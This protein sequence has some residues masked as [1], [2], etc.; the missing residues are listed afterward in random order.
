MKATKPTESRPAIQSGLWRIE[1]LHAPDPAAVGTTRVIDDVLTLGRASG[2]CHFVLEDDEASREHC[3]IGIADD[4]ES[5]WL[6][7]TGSRNGTFHDGARAQ[8]GV[9]RS[10]SVLRV[11]AHLLLLER[12]SPE[13]CEALVRPSDPTPGMVGESAAMH[14]LRA[15]LTEVASRSHPV[16]VLGESGTGKELVAREIHRHSGREGRFVAVNCAAIPEQLV[17]SE[18]FGHRRGAFTGA[19]AHSLGLFGEAEGGTIMLDEIAEMQAV[20]QAKLL[21]VLQSC[22]VRGV[23]E[24]RERRID[25]RVVAATNVDVEEAMARGQLRGDLYARLMG[26]RVFVPPLRTRRAD[27]LPTT[28]HFLRS[29]GSTLRPTVD[30]AEALLL[31]SWR[32]NVRE[33][34]QLV[35]DV[36]ERARAAGALQLTQLPEVMRVPVLAREPKGATARASVPIELRVPADRPPTAEELEH[37]LEHFGG[38]VAKVASYF[39]KD[40][41]QIYRW[42]RKLGVDLDVP[43][44]NAG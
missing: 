20:L 4:G 18:L 30:A 6:E 23:G 11:G 31:W 42:A 32:F 37:A 40:R 22:E 8:T 29:F 21:R 43:R 34:E 7:D 2:T 14:L 9:A 19:T 3:R 41:K 44:G 27:V 28:E 13:Q 26:G 16:L 33:L 15:R 1:V 39:G 38:N 35:V 10:G 36:G 12:L 17:E 25:V 5:C 24:T